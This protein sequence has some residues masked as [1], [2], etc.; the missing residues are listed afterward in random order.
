[1]SSRSRTS[2]RKSPSAIGLRQ[3]LPVQTKTIFLRSAILRKG[4]HPYKSGRKQV[5]AARNSSSFVA[6]AIVD[7]GRKRGRFAISNRGH[8]ERCNEKKRRFKPLVARCRAAYRA[9]PWTSLN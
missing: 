5:N 3:M 2:A 8:N 9:G 7:R 1:M 6:A 4:E